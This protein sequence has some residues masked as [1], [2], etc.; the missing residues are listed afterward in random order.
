MSTEEIWK[1]VLEGFYVVSNLG[2]VKRLIANQGCRA[3]RIMKTRPN[4]Y[5]YLQFG[6]S[7][8]GKVQ[9]HTVHKLVAHAFIGPRPLGR[10]VNHRNCI[11]TDN[12]PV[13]LEYVTVQENI[14]HAVKNNLWNKGERSGR[15]E[16]TNAEVI[17]IRELK[18][19]GLSGIAIAKKFSVTTMTVHNIVTRKHWRHI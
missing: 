14:A 2:R 11:K 4:K 17:K 5:G 18:N 9:N 16:L 7:V 1:P 12:T 15:S 3:G 19:Q 13:N 8:R 6:A 10:E